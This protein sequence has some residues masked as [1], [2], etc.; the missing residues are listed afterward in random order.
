MVQYTKNK[1]LVGI[2]CIFSAQNPF[3]L[4]SII[5]NDANMMDVEITE[6]MRKSINHARNLSV[7]FARI[8]SVDES[9]LLIILL[10]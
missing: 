2:Y 5:P 8:I 3:S 1:I 9:E 4:N 7:H 10:E 6:T